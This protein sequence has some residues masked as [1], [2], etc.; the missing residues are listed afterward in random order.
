MNHVDND[1][2]E[3]PVLTPYSQ[4]TLA[5]IAS[6]AQELID[7]IILIVIVI[8]M[9]IKD[10]M[11]FAIITVLIMIIKQGKQ[12]SKLRQLSHHNWTAKYF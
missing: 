11:M 4:A 8:I 9:M 2:E 6:G 5:G 12:E 3:P 1:D 10:M 7:V